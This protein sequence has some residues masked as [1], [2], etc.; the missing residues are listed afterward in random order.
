MTDRLNEL[1]EK[2]GLSPMAL[3]FGGK[4]GNGSDDSFDA[5]KY[6][7]NYDAEG[8]FYFLLSIKKR[9]IMNHFI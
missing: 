6:T 3:E 2:A 4:K 8:N 1:R 7:D 9:E 5:N